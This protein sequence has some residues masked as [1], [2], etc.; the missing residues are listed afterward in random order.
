MKEAFLFAYRD[1]RICYI[2]LKKDLWHLC[3]FGGQAFGGKAG[4]LSLKKRTKGPFR[5]ESFINLPRWLKYRGASLS[6]PGF[7]GRDTVIEFLSKVDVLVL[8]SLPVRFYFGNVIQLNSL[9]FR[10][11]IVFKRDQCS[12]QCDQFQMNCFACAWPFT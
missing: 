3:K 9:T 6:I 5:L 10:I 11:A 7:I 1:Q 12:L 2:A 4:R 8:Y